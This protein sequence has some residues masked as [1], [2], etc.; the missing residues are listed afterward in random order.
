MRKPEDLAGK[1]F[2]K[3]IVLE[4]DDSHPPRS[5]CHVYWICECD[6][7]NK[8]SISSGNL[9]RGY[10]KSCGCYQRDRLVVHGKSKSRIY[11]IWRAMRNRCYNPN[12]HNYFDYGGRGIKVCREWLTDFSAFYF[13]SMASGY[14]DDLSIDRIDV[15]GNYEPSNCRWATAKEQAN[16]RRPR[17]KKEA[18]V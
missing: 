18:S 5:G 15:D 2:G 10:Q 3:L 12:T 13:W 14:Q 11:G 9:K 7:G 1:Q 16:N 4:R 6:C 8:V 17:Q